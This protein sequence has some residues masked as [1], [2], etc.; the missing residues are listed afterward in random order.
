MAVEADGPS[1]RDDELLRAAREAPEGDMR[2]FE[3]LIQ[4]HRRGILAD[5]RFLTRDV[6]NAE[7]LARKYL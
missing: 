6:N 2:A 5:C 3:E 1:D 7:D 4:R